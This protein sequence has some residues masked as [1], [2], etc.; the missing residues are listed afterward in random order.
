MKNVAIFRSELLPIS[1]TFIR[2]QARSLA[3]WNPIL[4]GF[5]RPHSGLEI[6]DIDQEISSS[7]YHRLQKITCIFPWQPIPF[8]VK[9]LSRRNIDLIHVHFGTDATDVWPSVKKAG[10]PILVT[11]HGYD[12]NIE[13][14]WWESGKGGLKRKYYPRRLLE[15]AQDPHIRFLVVSHELKDVAVLRGIPEEKISVAHIGVDLTRFQRNDA[16]A[17]DRRNKILFVG[18]MVEKKSPLL[19]VKIFASVRDLIP[20]AELTMIGDGPLF[21]R[22]KLLA[23]QLGCPIRFL[24]AQ[25]SE[26]V[27]RELGEAKV[28]CLPSSRATNGDGE[29]FGLVLLEAQASGVPVVSSALGGASDGLIHGATGYKCA[30]G[31]LASFVTYIA[32]LLQDNQLWKS[33]SDK[34]IQFVRKN[35]D[36]REKTKELE[37]NYD[38][39]VLNHSNRAI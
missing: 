23:D 9:S 12:I 1:E 32:S 36:I 34:A 29:G 3:T 26:V 39:C 13:H 16:H 31:D 6:N 11:L 19:M 33:T 30:E 7:I 37:K 24:G 18:R 15:M 20:D 38:L 8:L 28:L 21:S 35:F 22:T 2:D 14:S 4:Y 5:N 10:L 25:P 27:Q 17:L